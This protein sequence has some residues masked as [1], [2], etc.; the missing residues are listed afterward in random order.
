MQYYVKLC[1]E[2][3]P[4]SVSVCEDN[5]YVDDHDDDEDEDD[6]AEN[7]NVANDDVDR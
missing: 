3:T 2:E 4:N 7:D 1:R 6:D 5:V